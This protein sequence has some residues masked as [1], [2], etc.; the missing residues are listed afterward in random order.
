M[1]NIKEFEENILPIY[2]RH[3]NFASF[4]RQL[5]MY[6]FHKVRGEQK[7]I[8]SHKLF[9]RHQRYSCFHV[10]TSSRK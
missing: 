2:F 1:K 9:Q 7:H 6:D 8:F 4:V 5:N 3:K 10:G